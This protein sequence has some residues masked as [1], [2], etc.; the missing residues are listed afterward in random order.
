M[1]KSQLISLIKEEIKGR[2]FEATSKKY[3]KQQALD[4][5][6][7]NDAKIYKIAASK[8]VDQ[9]IKD[10]EKAIEALKASKFT[11]FELSTYG[12]VIQFSLPFDE[13]HAKAVRGMG[14]LD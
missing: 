9:T 14:G 6:S 5:L 4:Y 10:K 13:E 1:K 2:L 7:K 12:D 8:G 3:T 11:E